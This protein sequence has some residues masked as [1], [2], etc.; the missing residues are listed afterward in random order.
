M[1]CEAL[2]IDETQYHMYKHVHVKN[3]IKMKR[4]YASK[5]YRMEIEVKE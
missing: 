2:D 4:K 3:R 1:S 5:L